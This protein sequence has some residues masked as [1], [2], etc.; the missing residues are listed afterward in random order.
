MV[1]SRKEGTK[2]FYRVAGDEVPAF[3]ASLR[4]LAR[5]RAAE[6]G[7]VVRDYFLARD[8]L[9]PVGCDALMERVG[10]GGVVVIDVRPVSE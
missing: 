2:V 1:E 9:E 5:D 3:V 8:A 10:R 6:V 4:D 7:Q